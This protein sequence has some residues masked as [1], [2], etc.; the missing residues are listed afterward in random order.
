MALE[1]ESAAAAKMAVPKVA[2]VTE[3]AVTVAAKEVVVTVAVVQAATMEEAVLA[4]AR[5]AEREE[6]V[7]AVEGGMALMAIRAEGLIDGHGTELFCPLLCSQA[8]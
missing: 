1:V 6:E 8:R 2:A 4:A 5:A 7:M 3:A